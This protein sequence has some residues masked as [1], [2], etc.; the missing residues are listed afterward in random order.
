MSKREVLAIDDAV[1]FV[2]AILGLV[3]RNRAIRVGGEELRKKDLIRVSAADGEGIA[4]YGPLG[5]AIEAEHFSKI[6]Q[7]AGENEPARMTIVA[8]SPCGL[9][10]ELCLSQI[11]VSVV[12]VHQCSQ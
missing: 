10:E 4:D 5:L 3:I 12:V 6:V 8:N 11:G 9:Q 7:K 2:D 1:R